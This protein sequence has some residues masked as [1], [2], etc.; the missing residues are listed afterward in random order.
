MPSESGEA[1]PPGGCN[2]TGGG[3]TI[4]LDNFDA[5]P[6]RGSEIT[7]EGAAKYCSDE[8]RRFLCALENVT[9]IYPAPRTAPKK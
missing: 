4:V 1:G 5:N 3:K 7:V 9:L 8:G 2:L 6:Y